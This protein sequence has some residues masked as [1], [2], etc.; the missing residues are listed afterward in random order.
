MIPSELFDELCTA[1]YEV[2]PGDLGEN[3]TTS[4][5]ELERLPSG[6]LLRLGVSAVIE[7]T[8]LRTRCVLIDRFR[9][10]LKNRVTR[11]ASAVSRFRCGVL[12]VVK[13][14]GLVVAGDE[15]VATVPREP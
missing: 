4:G 9:A 5:L 2:H 13:A 8:G 15:A 10:G 14:G 3:V 12:G 1:G 6:T 7:L 11:P